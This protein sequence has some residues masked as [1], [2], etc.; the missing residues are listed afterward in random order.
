[1]FTEEKT[2]WEREMLI[3]EAVEN[4]EKG[5]TVHLKNGA[6]IV[7]ASDSPSIDLIIY[8][9]EKQFAGIMNGRE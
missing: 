4:A 9:L 5:F 1:M 3:R 7:V 8:G 2:S 6:R